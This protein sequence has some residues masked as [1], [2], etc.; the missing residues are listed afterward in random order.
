VNLKKLL[1]VQRRAGDTLIAVW[2][3]IL[4]ESQCIRCYYFLGLPSDPVQIK[5]IKLSPDPPVPGE[6][7]TVIVDGIVSET[8]SVGLVFEDIFSVR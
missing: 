8:L 4:V 2:C 1:S 7:L 6:D 3:S 5:S